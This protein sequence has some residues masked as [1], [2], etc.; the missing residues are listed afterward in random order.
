MAKADRQFDADVLIIGAGVIG[1]M[2]AREL[3]RFRL[4]ITVLERNSDVCEGSS[5]SNSGMIHAGFHPR[6]GSLK[7]TSCVQGNAMYDRICADLD[8]PLKRTGSLYV[9]FGPNGEEKLRQK[10]DNGIRNGV[11]GMEIISGEEARRI[12]PCLSEKVL[13]ALWAPTAAIISPFRLVVALYESAL[14]NGVEFNL[15]T[16]V[17]EITPIRG[18]AG[19]IN[20]WQI[21]TA[22]GRVFTSRYVINAAGDQA[23]PLDAQVHPADLVIR[24]RRGQFY[25]FDCNSQVRVPV[26][27]A[28][29]DDE[30][31]ILATPT[32]E[33]NL[34]AGPTSENVADYTHTETTGEGLAKVMR[35]TQKIFPDIDPGD[36]ITSFAGVRTNIKNIEKEQK[37]FVV[38]L[39]AGHFV[40]ALGIKNPGMSAAPALVEKM[41]NLLASD[42]LEMEQEPRFDPFRKAYVP[43][44]QSDQARQKALIADDPS[45]AR[46]ICRCEKITEGD[47][48]YIAAKDSCPHT[49]EAIKCRLRTGMGR[50]QGGFCSPR[51]LGVLSEIWQTPPEKIPYS[52]AGGAVCKGKVK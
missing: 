14:K 24:P 17:R 19:A 37:D 9:A 33:G 15:S 20:G 50:C 34:L 49:I 16:E 25:V 8:V 51:V 35:V 26:Y 18:T 28:Q 7:G 2:A 36:V 11:P 27:Q 48:R 10:Y 12:E 44:L 47:V 21:K 40:S 30:G 41:L 3:A 32:I 46:I 38:R 1:C 43:F 31:G 29:E 13:A 42:G 45:Y 4:R 22:D 6:G 52:E 39:S 5:K 23:E